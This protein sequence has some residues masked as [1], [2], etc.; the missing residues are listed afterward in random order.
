MSL[1][2]AVLPPHFLWILGLWIFG[3]E[4]IFQ[5]VRLMAKKLIYGLDDNPPFPIMVLAGVQHA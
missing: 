2:R 1:E 5:E 4:N 3:E